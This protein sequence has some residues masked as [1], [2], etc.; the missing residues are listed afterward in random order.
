MLIYLFSFFFYLH[1][2]QI[3]FLSNIAKN[4]LK[5]PFRLFKTYHFSS[6]NLDTKARRNATVGARSGTSG[7]A[8]VGNIAETSVIVVTGRTKPPRIRAA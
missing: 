6:P 3:V 7:I 8:T 4:S 5:M 2:K 1:I